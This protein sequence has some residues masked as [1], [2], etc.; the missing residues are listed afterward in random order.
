MPVFDFR[1][2]GVTT[3]TA[4]I[5]KYG[6]GAKVRS[7][8]QLLLLILCDA[9]SASEHTDVT[10]FIYVLASDSPAM[11]MY[12]YAYNVDYLYNT[13]TQSG[14]YGTWTPDCRCLTGCCRERVLCCTGTQTTESIKSSLTHSGLAVCLAHPA[15]PAPDQVV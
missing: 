14:V 15:W 7:K 11:L 1:L 8:G 10:M 4:D 5:H 9:A 13:C 6:F 2:A 12:M 3:M